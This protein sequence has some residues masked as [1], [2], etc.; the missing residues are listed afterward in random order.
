MYFRG[1]GKMTKLLILTITKNLEFI[2]G[3]EDEHTVVKRDV[4]AEDGAVG[5]G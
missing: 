4:P 1:H 3:M 5:R 2:A